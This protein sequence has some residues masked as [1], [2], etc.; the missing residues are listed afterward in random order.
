ME[1]LTLGEPLV[2]PNST[3]TNAVQGAVPIKGGSPWLSYR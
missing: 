2:H 3:A 1:L